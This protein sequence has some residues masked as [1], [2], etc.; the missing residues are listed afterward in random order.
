MEL[1]YR[2]RVRAQ[3]VQFDTSSNTETELARFDS[4][5]F[6]AVDGFATHTGP[7]GLQT[8]MDLSTMPTMWRQ[9]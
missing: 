2:G 3:L 1:T 4:A 7:P 8:V 6:P 5:D 9:P